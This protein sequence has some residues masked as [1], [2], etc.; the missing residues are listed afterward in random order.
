LHWVMLSPKTHSRTL[1]F[2][3]IILKYD[4]H[5][6]Y[7]NQPL[8]MRMRVSYLDSWSWTVMIL[9]DTN[10][11]TITPTRAVLLPFVTYILTLPRALQWLIQ[12]G[13]SCQG[14]WHFW[15]M[16]NA[17]R[18]FIGRPKWRQLGI[19]RLRRENNI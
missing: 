3:S 18:M 9:S 13:K 7:W 6:D 17:Y 12:G 16:R 15:R 1:F 10:R 8:N 5:F 4:R 11:N 2:G 19:P 14:M